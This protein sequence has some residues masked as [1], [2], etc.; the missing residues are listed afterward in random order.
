L[1]GGKLNFHVSLGVTRSQG[2][3]E[4]LVYETK[5]FLIKIA[6]LGVLC[7]MEGQLKH[8]CSTSSPQPIWHFLRCAKVQVFKHA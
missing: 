4:N 7:T 1:R 6:E 8:N 5:V 2:I 3:N